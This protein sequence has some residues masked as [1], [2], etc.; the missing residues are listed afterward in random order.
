MSYDRAKAFVGRAKHQPHHSRVYESSGTHRT[1]FDGRVNG[2]SG[3]AIVIGLFS[4]DA[5]REYLSVSGRVVVRDRSVRGHSRQ[6]AVRADDHG[7][8]RNLTQLGG[9]PGSVDRPTHKYFILFG[10]R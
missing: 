3:K 8:N 5:K 6:L 10:H 7:P 1:W 9:F 2:R 4:G